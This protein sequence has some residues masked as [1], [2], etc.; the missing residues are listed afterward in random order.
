M[1]YRFL[2]EPLIGQ[3]SYIGSQNSLIDHL[4][5]TRDVEDEYVGGAT[6]I[7]YLEQE[8][9]RY[10]THVSDHRLVL[11]QFPVF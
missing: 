11:S 5:I 1:N 4:M 6:Q 3:A 9:D 7:L 8:F 10:T 2:T